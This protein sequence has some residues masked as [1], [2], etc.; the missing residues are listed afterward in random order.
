MAAPIVTDA[1]LCN[2]CRNVQAVSAF[3]YGGRIN[4]R[5]RE[6]HNAAGRA[7]R[8]TAK[9][10]KTMRRYKSRPEIQKRIKQHSQKRIAER[11][12]AENRALRKTP[13]ARLQHQIRQLRQ[14]IKR[15]TAS[16]YTAGV[17]R[18]PD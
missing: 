3:D 9:Y 2:T 16:G 10:R 14:R 4:G 18:N 1:K 13:R 11:D 7:Y 5:C 17:E 6:C 12:P 15:H 8:K